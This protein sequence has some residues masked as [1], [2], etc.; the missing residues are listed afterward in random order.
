MTGNLM[1]DNMVI[2]HI[3][4]IRMKK[5]TREKYDLSLISNIGDDTSR[6]WKNE[7]K[8]SRKKNE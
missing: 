1:E 4:M 2:S 5:Y 7:Y 6:K 3:K 8:N